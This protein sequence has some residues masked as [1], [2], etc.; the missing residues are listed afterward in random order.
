MNI[1]RYNALCREWYDGPK[2][3]NLGH[4]LMCHHDVDDEQIS[5]CKNKREAASLFFNR[6]VVTSV[7]G[8]ASFKQVSDFINHQ[9]FGA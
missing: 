5:R 7:N 2:E 9:N 6:Y 8:P 1:E 4:W 3:I